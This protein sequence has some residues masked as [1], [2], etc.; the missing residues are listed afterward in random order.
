MKYSL[1]S[2]IETLMLGSAKTSYNN[3]FLRILVLILF[4]VTNVEQLYTLNI[5]KKSNV[6]TEAN[7][8]GIL[9]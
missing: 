6:F 9:V 8:F 1:I 4:R 2:V 3:L 5:V 7:L